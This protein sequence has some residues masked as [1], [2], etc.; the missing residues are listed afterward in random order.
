MPY[1]LQ[2]SDVFVDTEVRLPRVDS[3]TMTLSFLG[4][5]IK[6]VSSA[7]DLGVVVDS[8]LTY[9]ERITNLAVSCA[10]ELLSDQ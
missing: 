1:T 6:P 7:K 3:I 5:E 10:T 2:T 8:H 9:N 4:K